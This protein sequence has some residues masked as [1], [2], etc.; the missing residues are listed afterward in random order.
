ML[1]PFFCGLLLVAARTSL[2][3]ALTLEESI[4][5]IQELRLE[6]DSTRDVSALD[7][8]LPGLNL[9]L[10]KGRLAP[11]RALHFGE[12]SYVCAAYFLGEGTLQFTAPVDVEQAQL[13]R[14]FDSDT[15]TRDVEE[16]LLVFSGNFYDSLL[17]PLPPASNPFK[18]KH[19]T[20]ARTRLSQLFESGD[21][22]LGVMLIRA[23]SEP[24]ATPCY[25]FNIKPKSKPR[26]FYLFDPFDRDEVVLRNHHDL[27]GE[28][29][30]EVVSAFPEGV[31]ANHLGINGKNKALLEALHYDIDTR[32]SMQ[33]AFSA[34]AVASFEVSAR[35]G[36]FDI[37][38][39]HP[40]LQV[41]SVR[42]ADST[43][44]DF[45]GHGEK[46]GNPVPLYLQW[47]E[48]LRAHDTVT[49]VFDYAGEVSRE[50]RGYF[51]VTASAQWYP[52]S[53]E[54][55]RATFDLKFATPATYEFV[56][57][58]DLVE[59]E[60]S[61]DVRHTQWNLSSPS[62]NVSFCIG[63][64]RRFA[65][66]D[67]SG[68]TV[69]LLFTPELHRDPSLGAWS[70]GG[71]QEKDIAT[72]VS[73]ALSLFSEYFGAYSRDHLRV[74]EIVAFH[75]E[76]FPGLIH[77]GLPTWVQEDTR[78]EQKVFRAHEVAH[79]WWGVEV[80]YDSYRDQWL[81]EAFAE[82]SALLYLER[83][84][85]TAE[86]L[87]ALAGYRES[88]FSVRSYAFG[89]GERSGAIA[90]GYR[91]SSSR[92][93]GDF[94]LVVY[95][96]GAYV[97]HML[98]LLLTDMNTLDDRRFFQLLNEFYRTYHGRDATTADFQAMSERYAGQSLQWF[99]TQWLYGEELP[100]CRLSSE[101]APA[102][103]GTWKLRGEISTRGVNDSFRLEV[104][105]EVQFP[106]AAAIRKRFTV[107]GAYGSFEMNGLPEEPRKVVLNPLGAVLIDVK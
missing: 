42:M 71:H 46:K 6:R 19:D 106:A 69:E 85:G 10:E 1:A 39:L 107:M 99:F 55:S 102:G 24:A 23:L 14:F 34:R 3:H 21:D 66:T 92:T 51:Y 35:G 37:L 49:L 78:G 45:H 88:I 82:Y 41:T 13:H 22:Y 25:V 63:P 77:M 9:H 50:A 53:V 81:S 33:G 5:R 32:I 96:K 2:G 61:G 4:E 73:S 93:E 52:S 87:R 83:T 27:P 105:I 75:G 72:D 15:L 65:H 60:R 36:R 67:S 98:R 47:E 31:T 95:K 101:K 17:A 103:D 57:T 56:A 70:T 40:D 59:D 94:D 12:S 89:R 58:G 7:I 74:S 54:R 29:F 26:L 18:K 68:V 8:Q 64:T 62:R 16:A 43:P 84:R 97:L 11:M 80:G 76:A 79:Q 100:E 90:L 38:T 104:P 44:V 28:S 48:P 30:M 86:F 91:A 20:S